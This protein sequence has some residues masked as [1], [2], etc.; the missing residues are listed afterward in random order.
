METRTITLSPAGS[1]QFHNQVDFCVGTGRM[2]L[3][4][5]HEYLEEL[6]LVQKEIHFSHIR[7]HGLFSDDMAIYQVSEDGTPEY[8]YTYLDRVMDSYRAL[9][10]KPFLELG[11]MPSKMAS[12]TQ[13]I[14]YWKGNTTPPASYEAWTDM[15]KAVLTHLC[16]RYGREEVVTWP[17]EVWN[18][19]NLPGFWEHADM[20]EYFKLFH[21]TFEAVKE[22]DERFR[23]GGPAVCGGSDEVWIRAFLEYCRDN[24]LTPDFI[25]RH[26]YTTELPDHVGHYGYPE[27]MRAEDGFA[28][29]HTTREIIDSFPAYRGK[30]IHITEFNTS[31]IPNAPIHD[32]NRNAAYIAH[33]LSRLGDDNESYS[34][35]TFGDVFEEQ[36]VPFTPFHGGFGLVAEG[37]IPKP[38]FWTFAFFK[39]LKEGNARCILRSESEVVM[40]LEDGSYRGVVWNTANRR[41]GQGCRLTL[42]IEEQGEGCLLTRTVDETHCN[43]LKVWHDMGEPACLSEEQRKLLR[44]AA[45]PFVQ[46][47]RVSPRNGRQSV[48][49]P[50]EENGVV[51]FEW[52]PGGVKPDRGY[53]YGR[54][55]QYP[56]INPLTRLDY[57]DPDVIRVGDT[58]YMVSTTMHF[59]PGCEI[60]RSYDLRNWEHVSYVYDTLD[61]TPAQRLTGNENIYGKGMWA[62]SLR[63]HEGVYHICFVANDTHKTYHYTAAAPEGPWEKHEMEGFYHDCSLMFDDDGRRYIVYGNRQVWLTELKEDLSGPLPGGLHRLLVEDRDNHYLGYEGSHLYKINGRY[64][65]FMIHSLPD[66]WRRTEACFTADSLEGTF[67]GGDVLNDDYGLTDQGIAQG[68]IVDTPDGNWYAIQ[69]QDM[70]AAGRIPYLMPVSWEDGFP[71]FGDHGTVPKTFPVEST[72]PGHVYA[73]LFGSDD[74]KGELKTYWQFSHEPDLSLITHDRTAGTW[75]VRTDK[76]CGSLLQARNTLT[77]RMLWPGCAAEVTVDGSGLGEGDFAGLCALQACFGFV[78][79]TRRDGRLYLVVRTVEPQPQGTATGAAADEPEK[80]WDAVCVEEKPYLLKLEADFSGGRDVCSFFYRE[81][82]FWSRWQRLGPEHRL[83]FDL[84]HFCGCRFGLTVYSTVKA[85]GSAAFG[86]FIYRER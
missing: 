73:P 39:K 64:Y 33:Q 70:G 69:F 12:G 10:L 42:E 75:M 53:S 74:F 68:A 16:D 3:A 54:A 60:M 34:Y 19:P 57:P 43:P 24:G 82:S 81:K 77:Q 41:T 46:T 35:W 2:G 79:L 15:V 17:V 31:Y 36:G 11:F 58:Y 22:V 40:R 83:R 45:Q 47:R 66:K 18:E 4:L 13:T 5:H 72:R 62:A 14:F 50:V 63:Y 61:G 71:V 7:G 30:E 8:N 49:I 84:R 48:S 59:M 65:L 20:P 85:G 23:V 51:Y 55:E 78:G 26:H 56:Q 6:K 80:E 21:R 67:K 25:T 38:T 28:N 86:D 27:L 52:T 76:V 32:T 9:G 1:A 37:C 44:E 29:L